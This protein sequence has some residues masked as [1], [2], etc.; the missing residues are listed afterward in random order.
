MGDSVWYTVKAT[1]RD[2]WRQGCRWRQRR[3]VRRR[4]PCRRPRGP[5]TRPPSVRYT[6]EASPGRT[7]H[8]R[9]R[10]L[11]PT[12]SHSQ[13]PVSSS[14]PCPTRTPPAL[15]PVTEGKRLISWQRRTTTP[16]CDHFR[17][18]NLSTTTSSPTMKR[19]RYVNRHCIL[20]KNL[21][22]L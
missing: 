9:A 2:E 5:W 6:A 7:K 10:S 3:L 17:F 18:R 19:I 11:C 20:S 13:P 8:C 1:D 16:N 12:L 14:W 15:R 21:N 22:V 4:S